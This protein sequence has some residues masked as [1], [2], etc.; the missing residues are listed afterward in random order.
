MRNKLSVASLE[1][2]EKRLNYYYVIVLMDN[3]V[4]EANLR[5]LLLLV[6]KF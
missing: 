5:E 6:L 4:T 2:S 3:I 1:A